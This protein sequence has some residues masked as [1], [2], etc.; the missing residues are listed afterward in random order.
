[1]PRRRYVEREQEEDDMNVY[2]EETRELLLEDDELS[3]EEEGFLAGYE[4]AA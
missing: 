2:S 4:S 3:A 1:M